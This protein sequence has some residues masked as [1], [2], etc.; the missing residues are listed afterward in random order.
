MRGVEEIF[1]GKE[2]RFELI[3]FQKKRYLFENNH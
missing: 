2:F 1:F 3:F